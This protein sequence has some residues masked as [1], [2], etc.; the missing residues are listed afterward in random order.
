MKQFDYDNYLK[1]NPLYLSEENTNLGNTSNAHPW[2]LTA[3]EEL[4]D[5]LDFYLGPK[6]RYAGSRI[7]FDLLKN[8]MNNLTR[9]INKYQ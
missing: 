3:M 5:D 8:K 9:L 1:N 4:K 6:N 7:D 2:I